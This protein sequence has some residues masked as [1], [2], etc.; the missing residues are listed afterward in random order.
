T[1]IPQSATDDS[2]P[3]LT[4]I[5][6][7]NLVDPVMRAI[8]PTSIALLSR[9]N[10]A[11]RS[12]TRRGKLKAGAR[13]AREAE[14][15]QGGALVD[16]RPGLLN[17][18]CLVAKA[19][20]GGGMMHAVLPIACQLVHELVPPKHRPDNAPGSGTGAKSAH[21]IQCFAA[22]DSLW[23]LSS[24]CHA[25]LEHA[26]PFASDD[27]ELLSRCSETLVAAVTAT[28]ARTSEA[29]RDML[30]ALLERI[31]LSFPS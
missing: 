15:T 7:H 25:V 9:A 17:I 31:I 5:L 14:E 6:A 12:R 29:V 2:A 19:V 24:A 30:C 27:A 20:K 23:Y 18:V 28:E 26:A 21:R 4:R 22:A 1:R 10:G 8:H 16:V 3:E 13:A 11:T